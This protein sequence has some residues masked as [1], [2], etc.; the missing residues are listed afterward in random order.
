MEPTLISVSKAF[1]AVSFVNC[2]L[3]K[4]YLLPGNN[5]KT[6]PKT[7]FAPILGPSLRFLNW[8]L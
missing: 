6:C 5:V 3:F 8:F 7:L 1:L 2:D 4:T